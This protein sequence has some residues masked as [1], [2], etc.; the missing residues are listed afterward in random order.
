VQDIYNKLKKHNQQHV[1][2]FIDELNQLKAL[3]FC[4]RLNK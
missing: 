2:K 4:S 3:N 1:L